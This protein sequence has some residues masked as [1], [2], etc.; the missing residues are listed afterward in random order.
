MRTEAPS[1]SQ[2]AE[3]SFQSTLSAAAFYKLGINMCLGMPGQC[4]WK[5]F[6]T[7]RKHTHTHTP[8]KEKKRSTSEIVHNAEWLRLWF[9]SITSSVHFSAANFRRP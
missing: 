3:Q 6:S 8:G 7:I 1:G 2:T 4:I 9:F 5:I